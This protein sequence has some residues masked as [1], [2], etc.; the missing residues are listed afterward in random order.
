MTTLHQ[1]LC[2]YSIYSLQFYLLFPLVKI[3]QLVS[4]P[5]ILCFILALGAPIPLLECLIKRASKS[6]Y[7]TLVKHS[8]K[9]DHLHSS[10]TTLHVIARSA[11]LGIILSVGLSFIDGK[12]QS[13]FVPLGF[14][15]VLLSFFHFS[16]YF[17]TSLTNPSTLSTSSFLLDHS[18]AYIAAIS[19]S[20]VEYG[21]EVY[22]F[23]GFKKFNSIA[24]IGLLLA[25][26]GELIRKLAMFTAGRNFTHLISSKKNPQHKLVTNGIYAILRH[27]SYAGWFYWAVGSQILLQN[28]ICIVL[29]ALVS[30][31]FFRE[32]II[33][34]ELTLIDFFGDEYK[35]YKR[36][37]GLWMPIVL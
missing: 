18:T 30:Y 12:L 33:Y 4:L 14:Y 32:R 1:D 17:V 7:V 20:F 5:N 22:L 35:R 36:R 2:P 3:G 13:H 31:S 16:E 28:P 27:P 26:G 19:G 6:N 29:F 37:V 11:I 15:L 34:E 8:P 9:P 24:L 21:I 25:T 23:P 10:A